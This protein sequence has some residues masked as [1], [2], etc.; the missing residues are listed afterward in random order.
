LRELLRLRWGP[1]RVGK[2]RAL[3]LEVIARSGEATLSEIS[4]RTGRRR[5]NVRR[6]LVMAEARALVECSGEPYRLVP[7]FR[8]ALDAEL[9]ATGIKA[10]ERLDRRKYEREREAYRERIA[11][12]RLRKPNAWPAHVQ[13]PD[14]YIEDLEPVEVAESSGPT[15]DPE[16]DPLPAPEREIFHSSGKSAPDA[17]ITDVSDPHQFRELAYVLR[18]GLTRLEAQR[19]RCSA[20]R[21][22]RCLD[23]ER[24][25]YERRKDGVR[26]SPAAFLRAE[27]RGVSGMGYAE[28][29]R[30]WKALGGKA[31]TL[32]EAIS[33][34]PYRLKREPV[35][36]NRPYVY[37]A[38]SQAASRSEWGLR[39]SEQ[40]GEPK[41]GENPTIRP[42]A[43]RP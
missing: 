14:G 25:G 10:S 39:E 35:D 30:R 2:T 23:R 15:P 28:M 38:V 37:P 24:G 42:T 18:T 13:E 6:A 7:E 16:P 29:L 26:I 3:Y 19:V 4:E 43:R 33:A 41:S 17:L 27:L 40:S 1:G 9:E 20:R 32:E 31:E 5:D 36:F 34:G 21:Q 22:A 8:C 12:W 11:R